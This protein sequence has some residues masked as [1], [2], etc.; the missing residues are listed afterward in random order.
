MYYA[1]KDGGLGLDRTQA[2]IIM[3]IYGSLIYMSGIIGGWIADRIIGTQKAVF[4]GGILIM[5]GHIA[6]ALPGGAMLLYVSMFF[7][8]IGTGL[9]K[10]N[11]SAVV[12]D[13]Y[14]ENDARRDSGFSIFYMG[15]NMGGFLSPLLVGWTEQKWGFHA[16]FLVAAIGMFIGLVVFVLSK[17]S[18]GLAGTFPTNPMNAEEK[19]K[20]ARNF[21]IGGI[22]VVILG[23]HRLLNR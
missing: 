15:I 16:G 10:P 22:V 1:V 8:I 14:A 11:V 9:L 12:G 19:K 4:Y 6:L 5:V 7:I 2:N 21:T 18:L 17:K 3:S 23:I 13:L 20:S